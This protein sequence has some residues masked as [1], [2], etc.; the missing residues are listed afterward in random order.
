MAT[1]QYHLLS[2]IPAAEAWEMPPALEQ[3]AQRL[4]ASGQLRINAD[5]ERNYVRHGTA[6]SD[7]T[8]TARELTDPALLPHTVAELRRHVAPAAGESALEELLQH[9]RRELRKARGIDTAKEL[10]VARCVVQAAHPSVI[11]LV[12]QSGTEIFV[13][14]SHTVGD[15]LAVHDWQRH[16]DA[17]GLQATSDTGTAVYI[18]CGGD[19]FFE[20]EQKTWTTDGFPALAR[21]MVIGGQELG[22]FADLKRN[23]QG[24]VGRHS[25]AD[26]SEM[27]A[28]D[29]VRTARLGDIARLGAIQKQALAS[30]LT[31]LRRAEQAVAFYA[32]QKRWVRWLFAQVWRA[33]MRARF[34]RAVAVTFRTWP[35][36]MHGEAVAMY[37]EDMA[38]NLSPA[39]DAYRH[40]NPQVEEAIACIEALARVPQ[41]VHKWG[42]AAVRLAWPGLYGMYFGTVVPACVAAAGAKPVVNIDLL[43]KLT[44]LIRRT[45]RKR[46]GYYP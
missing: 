22:H 29:M 6:D 15:L 33:V 31:A 46:P 2:F 43:Q 13:S 27:R 4:V 26:A 21:M 42:D 36:Y 8:F 10:R 39:A 17:G 20:G 1:N 37:L 38:F 25:T 24:I 35:R 32:K 11:L 3:L 23:A 7:K 30:G 34:G 5:T 12:L 45:L 16:G 9:L 14:Y 40:P 18:S 28:S 44:I 41:Q 19:P